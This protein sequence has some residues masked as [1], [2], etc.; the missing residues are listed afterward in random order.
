MHRL[1]QAQ[2]CEAVLPRSH[3]V[4][5]LRQVG[6]TEGHG[7]TTRRIKYSLYLDASQLAELQSVSKRTKIPAAVIARE[8]IELIL[9]EYQKRDSSHALATSEY[10][11][12]H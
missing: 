7:M 10:V 6:E 9:K 8:G 3:D 4:Q 5:S 2:D 11:E 12:N 1:R